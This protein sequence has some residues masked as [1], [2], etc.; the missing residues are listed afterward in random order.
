MFRIEDGVLG[1]EVGVLDVTR[2]LFKDGIW[3]VGLPASLAV[4][5]DAYLPLHF[6]GQPFHRFAPGIVQQLS[7]HHLHLQDGR[8][9][10]VLLPRLSPYIL[11]NAASLLS[12][13]S[14]LKLWLARSH[15]PAHQPNRKGSVVSLKCLKI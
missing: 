11:A 3:L 6:A 2:L 12:G 8:F 14:F 13:R 7:M 10:S 5:M 4:F 1:F 15:P 9:V